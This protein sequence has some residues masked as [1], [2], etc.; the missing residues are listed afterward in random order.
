MTTSSVFTSH[1]S[2]AP[3]CGAPNRRVATHILNA[4][5]PQQT[6]HMHPGIHA[7]LCCRA[8]S[9]C[10]HHPAVFAQACV[11][12]RLP[13]PRAAPRVCFSRPLRSARAQGGQSPPPAV[14]ARDDRAGGVACSSD[15]AAVRCCVGRGE[16]GQ[17]GQRGGASF[18]DGRNWHRSG[19]VP[20]A[21]AHQAFDHSR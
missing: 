16:C 20:Q 5:F 13:R 11:H 6:L 15:G 19:A 21:G 3:R 10:L 8:H 4:P 7:P 2:S 18:A 1:A 17:R 12:T 9:A 14:C